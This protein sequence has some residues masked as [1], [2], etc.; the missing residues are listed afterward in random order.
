MSPSHPQRLLQRLQTP[1]HRDRRHNLRHLRD[2]TRSTTTAPH[3]MATSP[4]SKAD[5]STSSTR[6]AEHDH[7]KFP[8]GITVRDRR[9][10]SWTSLRRGSDTG[11]T[12]DTPEA[13]E[14]SA[15]SSRR[16]LGCGFMKHSA[17]LVR[18]RF[19]D[20]EGSL[21]TETHQNGT[22]ETWD[23]TTERLP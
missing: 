11:D 19:D 13:T 23:R 4:E 18:A 10:H 21:E 20:A 12:A 22:G 9:Q 15:A 7:R 6:Q 5:T 17:T 14:H 1:L 8:Q 3:W 16:S 2:G